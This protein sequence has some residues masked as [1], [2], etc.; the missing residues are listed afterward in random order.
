MRYTAIH[1]TSEHRDEPLGPFLFSGELASA[2]CCQT[3]SS[4]GALILDHLIPARDAGETL[5]DWLCRQVRETLALH[6]QADDWQEPDAKRLGVRSERHLINIVLSAEDRA[7]LIERY[8]RHPE[9]LALYDE[10]CR[11]D[12]QQIAA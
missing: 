12:G 1:T 11:A 6:V 2:I 8:A 10:A 5:E 9:V 4:P 7:W 3:D